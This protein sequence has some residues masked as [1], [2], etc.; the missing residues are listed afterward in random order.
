MSEYHRQLNRQRH[1]FLLTFFADQ[2]K[3][4][5]ASRIVNSYKLTKQWNGTTNQ[6]E[7]AIHPPQ[8]NSFQR[9]CSK[10]ID[11][12]QPTIKNERG[13]ALPF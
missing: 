10:L 5:F 6:W 1:E 4:Q 13:E 7:I 11:K 3:D 2:E 8:E 9:P 12:E